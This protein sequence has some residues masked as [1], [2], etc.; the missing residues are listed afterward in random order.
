MCSIFKQLPSCTIPGRWPP[1]SLTG[2]PIK[3]GCD[4]H[5]SLP[6]YIHRIGRANQTGVRPS[7]FSSLLHTQHWESQ[8]NWGCDHHP[9]LPSYI[10]S[11]GRANQTGVRPSP[12]SSLLHTQDWESQSNWGA[13]I[14]LLFPLTYTELGEPIKLGCDHHPS[15]PSYIHRIGRANQTGVRPSPFSSF[16]HTQNWESCLGPVRLLSNIPGTV[17]HILTQCL[18]HS[19]FICWIYL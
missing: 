4:H 6:S 1:S 18:T 2:P 14:T 11:I 12:F 7:P 9:S 3:L 10:H 17:S 19:V 13:T 8:S 16:L 5:P 15:L